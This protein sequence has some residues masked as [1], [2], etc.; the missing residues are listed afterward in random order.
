VNKLVTLIVL[1]NFTFGILALAAGIVQWISLFTGNMEIFNAVG[2]F[3]GFSLRCFWGGILLYVIFNSRY[4]F[5]GI[6]QLAG[7]IYTCAAK[8]RFLDGLNTYN[9]KNKYILP[10]QGEWLVVNGGLSKRSSHSWDIPAQRYAYDFLI[11]NMDGK[12][13]ENSRKDVRNYY[14][15]GRNILAPADGTVIETYNSCDDGRIMPFNLPDPYKKNMLGNYVI[16]EHSDQEYTLLAHLQKGSILF[17][18]GEKVKQ[19]DLIAKCGNTGNSSE[20]HLHFQ[21]QNSREFFFSCSLPVKFSDFEAAIFDKYAAVFGREILTDE[22]SDG[23][24]TRG[25]SAKNS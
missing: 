17:A 25:V 1:S 13:F 6:V 18:A 5:Q 16:I 10:F 14:C 11:V 12:S 23:Y 3:V 7:I 24:L 2:Y 20:P 8:K 22:L 4:A 9:Q 15:Y 19:G 21:L